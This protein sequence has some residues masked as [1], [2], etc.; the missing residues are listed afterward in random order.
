MDGVFF[1]LSKFGGRVVRS[2]ARNVSRPPVNE[3]LLITRIL[4]KLVGFDTAENHRL[5][6]QQGFI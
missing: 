4:L 6:N 2:E 1:I 3:E 5:L